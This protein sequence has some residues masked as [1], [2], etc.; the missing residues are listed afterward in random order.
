MKFGAYQYLDV[1]IDNDIC[2]LTINRPDKMNALNIQ[3]LQEIK[4]AV[5]EVETMVH[6]IILTGSGTKAFAAG[7]DIAEFA[8]FNEQQGREMSSNGHEVMNRVER[9]RIPVVA[10]VNGFAL[11]GGCE[12]AM[13]C[14]LR[15]ATPTARF[16]QPEVSL[17]LVPGYGGTQRL[18]LLIGRSK[19]LELL[20]TGDM[21]NAEQAELLGLVNAVVPEDELIPTCE[22]LIRKIASKSPNAVAKTIQL[23]NE[24][25]AQDADGMEQEQQ[26][27]GACFSSDEFVEGTDAFLNKRKPEFRK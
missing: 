5:S 1:R 25:Y 8:S 18:P 23:V 20:L 11:G 9:C 2:Y 24:L 22:K 10:A 4:H 13:A 15:I 27:F 21:I 3:L 12:L 19:G 16:G 14:H 7:A 17:G 6:G 26:L